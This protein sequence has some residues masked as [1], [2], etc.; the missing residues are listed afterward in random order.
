VARKAKFAG[1]V[2]YAL[3]GAIKSKVKELKPNLTTALARAV[4]HVEDGY[5]FAVVFESDNNT[6]NASFYMPE[7]GH[8]NAGMFL[9]ARHSDLPTAVN[10][11]CVL[12]EEVFDKHWPDPENNAD[13]YDW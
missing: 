10:L 11:L 7:A 12:H 9:A 3:D 6:Y 4:K 2:R 1:Y 5:K 13:Q 8:D